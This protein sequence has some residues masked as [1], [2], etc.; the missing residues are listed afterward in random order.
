MQFV[1]SFFVRIKLKLKTG[2]MFLLFSILEVNI[3]L[4]H[5]PCFLLNSIYLRSLFYRPLCRDIYI[6]IYITY[7]CF[8]FFFFRQMDLWNS[9][10]KYRIGSIMCTNHSKWK[11]DLSSSLAPS[12][13]NIFKKKNRNRRRF[14][15]ENFHQKRVLKTLI[16]QIIFVGQNK[17]LYLRFNI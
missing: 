7:H 17:L 2:K 9:K 8:F 15:F 3:D 14:F 10:G 1:L 12:P 11:H 4:Q 5:A 13:T 6:Y 16:I